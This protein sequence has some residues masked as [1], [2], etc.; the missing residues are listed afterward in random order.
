M[1]SV[2]HGPITYAGGFPGLNSSMD[3]KEHFY[4]HFEAE[5]TG[6]VATSSAL[7]PAISARLTWY[8]QPS[9]TRSPI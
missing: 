6:K 3:P 9:K 7:A 1:Q 4:R 5:A 2:M 8:L